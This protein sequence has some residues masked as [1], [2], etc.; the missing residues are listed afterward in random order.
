MLHAQF[1]LPGVGCE[2]SWSCPCS[3]VEDV[4]HEADERHLDVPYSISGVP[5]WMLHVLRRLVKEAIMSRHRIAR[6]EVLLEV[7]NL[8]RTGA[9]APSVKP[10]CFR[11]AAAQ[12]PQSAC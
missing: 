4:R 9:H 6:F 8:G 10:K 3:C 2:T 5:E 12:G 11:I 1:R 7:Y